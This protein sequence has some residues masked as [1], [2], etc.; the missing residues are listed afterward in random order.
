MRFGVIIVLLLALV[1][2]TLPHPV[3]ADCK[4]GDV[5]VSDIFKKTDGTCIDNPSGRKS[6]FAFVEIIIQYLTALIGVVMVLMIVIAGLQYVLA[7]SSPDNAKS[8]KT[9]IERAFTGLILFILM[10]GI[11]Q[12]LLPPDVALFK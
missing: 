12:I 7:G 3:L 2:I 5:A 1:A 4:I 6:I 11:L 8:A 9:R 10:F